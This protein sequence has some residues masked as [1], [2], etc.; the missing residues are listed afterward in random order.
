MSALRIADVSG[1]PR[2]TVRR[3][4]VSLHDKGWVEKHPRH[5]WY[6]VGPTGQSPA[7]DALRDLETRSYRRLARLHLRLS[8]IL[9]RMPGDPET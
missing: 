1:I 2:E 7:R 3:K 4:L 8:E 6:L 5:G 9:D